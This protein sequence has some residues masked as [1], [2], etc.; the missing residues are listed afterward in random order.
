MWFVLSQILA[1]P[2]NFSIED[3]FINEIL[4]GILFKVMLNFT[5]FLV[6]QV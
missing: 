5:F 6:I 3:Q 2:D 1:S 4:I